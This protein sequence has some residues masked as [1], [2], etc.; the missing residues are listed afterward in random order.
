MGLIETIDR[1]T[2]PQNQYPARSYFNRYL[3]LFQRFGRVGLF[4]SILLTACGSGS[5]TPPQ[6]SPLPIPTATISALMPT[7]SATVEPTLL[8]SPDPTPTFTHEKSSP[9]P[10]PRIENAEKGSFF[11]SKGETR[12]INFTNLKFNQEV[13]AQVFEQLESLPDRSPYFFFGLTADSEVG[14]AGRIQAWQQRRSIMMFE[15]VENSLPQG[16]EQ[17]SGIGD[18]S[19]GTLVL[20]FEID[21]PAYTLTRMKAGL[22]TSPLLAESSYAF[23]TEA[24][25]A[26]LKVS[27]LNINAPLNE[28]ELAEDRDNQELAQEVFCNS[29]G[30]A[31]SSSTFDVS[32]ETYIRTIFGHTLTIRGR[33]ALIRIIPEEEYDRL[34]KK[35]IFEASPAVKP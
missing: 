2:E 28:G 26:T 20:G 34:P 12:W 29:W 35:P 30:I 10:D 21:K 3:S 8:I 9:T 22:P 33:K 4:S 23:G 5:V 1:A 17:Q 32:Y 15:P 19:A 25:Q 7:Y 24:C 13:A 18:L 6:E 11:T 27:A 31:L 16:W 14:I